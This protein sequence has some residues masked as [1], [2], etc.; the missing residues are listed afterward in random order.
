MSEKFATAEELLAHLTA[1]LHLQDHT[2]TFHI[3]DAEIGSG[4][5][6]E[7]EDLQESDAFN[8]IADRLYDQPFVEIVDV[9]TYQLGSGQSE[10]ADW[11][12]I[13]AL[14]E[15]MTYSPKAFDRLLA[16]HADVLASLHDLNVANPA[17]DEDE[18]DEE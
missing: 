1:L 11:K 8:A 2:I 5:V 10:N 13:D 3:I 17:Y 9:T 6:M 18:L 4:M 14:I 12:E 15:A 7:S 16:D